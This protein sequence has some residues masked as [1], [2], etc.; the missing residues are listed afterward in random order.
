MFSVSM[1]IVQRILKKVRSY[2][3]GSTYGTIMLASIALVAINKV[4]ANNQEQELHAVVEIDGVDYGRLGNFTEVSDSVK[5]DTP[6]SLNLSLERTFVAQNSLFQWAQNSQSNPQEHPR[7]I[8]V[9]IR[10][11][12]GDEVDRY[13][14]EQTKPSSWSIEVVDSSLGGFRENVQVFVQNIVHGSSL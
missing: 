5:A 9:I 7:D 13:I 6:K 11:R 4:A 12:A 10:N 3:V 8:I 14:L 2:L 1:F